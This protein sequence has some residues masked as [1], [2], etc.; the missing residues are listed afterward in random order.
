MLDPISEVLISAWESPAW[1]K[2]VFPLAAW[3][4]ARLARLV[5]IGL[6]YASDALFAWTGKPSKESRLNTLEGKLDNLA[7]I[8]HERLRKP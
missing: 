4:S 5:W 8:L 1:Q 2:V 3:G 7:V 6:C